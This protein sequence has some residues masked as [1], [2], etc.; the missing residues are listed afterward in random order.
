MMVAFEGELVRIC[1][2]K[3][4]RQMWSLV[5]GDEIQFKHDLWL[6]KVC[7]GIIMQLKFNDYFNIW[8]YVLDEYI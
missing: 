3:P 1:D 7:D 4:L 8:D 6:C 2:L 5:L